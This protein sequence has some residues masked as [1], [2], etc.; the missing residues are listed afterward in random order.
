MSLRDTEPS[1]VYCCCSLLGSVLHILV[2]DCQ[3]QLGA[4]ADGATAAD[5]GCTFEVSVALRLCV[6]AVNGRRVTLTFCCSTI[7][8]LAVF[9]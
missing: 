8:L 3:H 4:L 2:V 9:T 6:S 7:R 1:N 5:V